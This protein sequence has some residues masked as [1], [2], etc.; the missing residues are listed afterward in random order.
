[1]SAIA[2]I[3]HLDGRPVDLMVLGRMMSH[4]SNWSAE[5]QNIW[6][7]GSTGF[8]HCMHYTTPQSMGEKLPLSYM[9]R[10]VITADARIDNRQEI[11]AELSLNNANAATVTDSEL[12]L[13]AYDK[14]G[15]HCPE[16]LLGDF[17][18]AIWDR[19]RRRLFCAR[20]PMAVKPFFYYHSDRLFVFASSVSALLQN[21][22]VPQKLN[23]L[24]L[25]YFVARVYDDKIITFYKDIIRL[26]GGHS[27]VVENGQLQ[28]RQYWLLNPEHEIRL[29]SNEEY[30]EAM[31][32]IFFKSVH[33]R[34][35]SAFPVGSMLSGGLDSSS[36]V[37]AARKII[38]D[39]GGKP[40][41]TF[42]AIFPER[43]RLDTRIDER[44]YINAVSNL[45]N[46]VHHDVIA[47]R[48]TPLLDIL[49]NQA[50]PI[51]APNAYLDLLIFKA[52]SQQGIRV[53]LSGLDGDTTV[54]YGYELFAELTRRGQWIKLLR[55]IRA[56]CR[57]LGWPFW[58]VIR[59]LCLR[60]I[61]PESLI[62]AYRFVRG[63]SSPSLVNGVKLDRAFSERIGLEDHLQVRRKR[64]EDIR[65]C[66][67]RQI[68]LHNI[69]AELLSNMM[70]MLRVI[71][72]DSAI[73]LRFP[74]FDRRLIEF[75]LA[76]PVDQKMKNGES[77]SIMRR[78]MQGLLPP[79]VRSRFHKGSLSA[80]F[81]KGFLEH[82]E[83][84]IRNILA[85]HMD[86]ISNYVDAE[87]LKSNF[88]KYI[89]DPLQGDNEA[90]NLF[91]VVTLVKWLMQSG[92]S[93]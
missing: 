76:L 9:D 23:E 30:E 71:A 12:I 67:P 29:S 59:V 27:L 86:L 44:G 79:I 42:S 14:W 66:S 63:R 20:D 60:P 37:C 2:G 26:P 54:S 82:E 91:L 70:D 16:H 19:S 73:D 93:V 22:E 68:H 40:L 17:S 21:S 80:N 51:P 57:S 62:T 58:G 52:A 31:R 56:A 49:W 28:I 53:L 87:D 25:A 69:K 36:I 47:D 3:Y 41:H 92:V 34:L 18:F 65:R 50:E 88:E 74:Y 89:T 48:C 1:M 13:K 45:S 38:Q 4:V 10:L 81:D 35:R 55:E 85:N 90:F 78:A 39:D 32:E 15:G 83:K 24:R 75:C 84:L 61:L 5:D 7:S 43:A 11:M 6:S 64:E 46:I 33:C 8:G 72:D 77:R